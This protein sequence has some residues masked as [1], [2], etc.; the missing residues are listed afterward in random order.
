M[1]IISFR[2]GWGRWTRLYSR[3]KL[4]TV[5]KVAYSKNILTFPW[6]TLFLDLLRWK[7]RGVKLKLPSLLTLKCPNPH[8]FCCTFSIIA[9]GSEAHLGGLRML[10]CVCVFNTTGRNF[11]TYRFEILR[12][13]SLENVADRM[14]C[15]GVGNVSENLSFGSNST[16]GTW[17]VDALRMQHHIEQVFGDPNLGS[18]SYAHLYHNGRWLSLSPVNLMT[19]HSTELGLP[20]RQDSEVMRVSIQLYTTDTIL[21]TARYSFSFRGI[22]P[23]NEL[24]KMK[25]H[26]EVDDNQFTAIQSGYIPAMEACFMIWLFSI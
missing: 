2:L 24:L 17:S 4:R 7:F 8:V 18:T 25:F 5:I 10:L 3:E 1:W 21:L 11:V 26:D 15:R 22:R 12:I 20:R 19:A 6:I 16:W 13:D 14:R 9:E 23:T